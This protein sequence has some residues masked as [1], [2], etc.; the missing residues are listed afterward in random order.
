ML[1]LRFAPP[2][3]AA[4]ALAPTTVAAESPAP[5]ARAVEPVYDAGPVE[6]GES[7]SHTFVLAN[8]GDAPLEIREVRPTC[9][10]TVAEFDASIPPGQRGKVSTEVDTAN[11]Q[12]PMAKSVTVFT[13]DMATPEIRL[14]VKFDVRSLVEVVPDYVRLMM[15]R[16][17]EPE[18]TRHMI[19]FPETGGDYRVTGVRTPRPELHAEVRPATPEERAPEGPERQWILVTELDP[20]TPAGPLTGE[21]VVTTTHPKRPEYAV[22]ITGYV[23]EPLMTMPP[24]LDLGSFSPEE[25]RKASL[26]VANYGSAGVE[27]TGFESDVEGL[28]A[29]FDPSED[30]RRIDVHLT[31]RPGHPPGVLDGILTLRTTSERVPTLTVPVRGVIQ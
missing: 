30:G 3:L 21:V 16:G 29:E 6:R 14:T 11:F 2:L 8:E 26:I 13:N 7:V 5:K 17:E 9:G 22:P 12:G 27:I 24:R 10:C 1:R 4:L 31:L 23:R 18:R 28:V 15:V 20:D 25:P 19:W